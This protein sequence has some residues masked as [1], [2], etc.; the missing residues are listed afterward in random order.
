MA[1]KKKKPKKVAAAGVK[2]KPTVKK[3]VR[4]G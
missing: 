1:N 3:K 2:T 4:R